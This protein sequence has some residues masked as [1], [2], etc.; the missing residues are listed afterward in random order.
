LFETVEIDGEPLKIPAIMPRLSD[1]P[2]GTEWPGGD[3]GAHTHEVLSELLGMSDDE[4]AH[5]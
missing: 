2:G 1:S 5:L 4:I 3:V